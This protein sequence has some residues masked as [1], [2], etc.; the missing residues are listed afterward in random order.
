MHGRV[1]LDNAIR[2]FPVVQWLSQFTAVSD[3]AGANLYATCPVCGGRAKLRIRK[4]N[5]A[6]KCYRC[7]D[8]GHGVGKWNGK[9]SLVSL[10][11]HLEQL[12]VPKAIE[13]IGAQ[14]GVPDLA[15]VPP[16]VPYQKIPREA[17]PLSEFDTEHVAWER[18]RER[19]LTHLAPRI[20]GCVSGQYADRWILPANFL[21]HTE[22]IEAKSWFRTVLPKALY[23]VWFKTPEWVY[24]TYDWD[25]SLGFAV[26]TESIFDAETFQQNAIGL[27]GSTLLPGQLDRLLELRAKGIKT[28]FW[29]LDPDAVKKQNQ[30]ILQKTIGLF[31]NYTVSFPCK[32]HNL[33]SGSHASG[34]MDPNEAGQATC[35]E[36]LDTAVPIESELDL[37]GV[38]P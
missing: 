38:T 36:L 32:S 30:A 37:L 5:R 21:G 25:F 20:F 10:V 18:L 4:E 24:T 33:G 15:Y 28:L 27:Y 19:K 14:A 22:G 9:G 34:K 3:G 12:T 8:G 11:A 29:A 13:F 23:P 16:D 17:L 2:A 6:W 31:K 26:V 1:D 35:W 7:V